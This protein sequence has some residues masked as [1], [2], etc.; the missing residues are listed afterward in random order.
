MRMNLALFSRIRFI[1]IV[2]WPQAMRIITALRELLP[3]WLDRRL[4]LIGFAVLLLRDLFRTVTGKSRLTRGR[5]RVVK[6][7]D[8]T[9]SL[10][11]CK[12][13]YLQL[14]LNLT[15]AQD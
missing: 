1:C 7:I 8:I 9:Y 6:K 4:V 11:V 2:V 5:C 10:G 3:Y 12:L 14:P 13:L 15:P